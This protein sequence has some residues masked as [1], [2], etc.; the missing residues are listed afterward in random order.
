[1]TKLRVFIGIADEKLRVAMLLLLGSER[2]MVLVG[3]TDRL[4]GL[5]PQVDA[6]QPDVLLLDW[7]LSSEALAS[8]ISRIR[9]LGHPLKIVFLSSKPEN[10]QEVLETGA[11][12]F[13]AKNAPPDKLLL[14]LHEQQ[15]T[16]TEISNPK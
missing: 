7:V 5:V 11:D 10:E 15:S 4:L 3:I 9:S 8:L 1:M 16:K 12:Y 6:T 2:G 13:I 14:F